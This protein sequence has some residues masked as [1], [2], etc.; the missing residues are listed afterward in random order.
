[1]ATACSSDVGAGTAVDGL[2]S[3]TLSGPIEALTLPSTEARASMLTWEVSSTCRLVGRT[4]PPSGTTSPTSTFAP[5]AIEASPSA[6]A[7]ASF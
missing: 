7:P 6:P 4:V 1:M 2:P 5:T 3:E